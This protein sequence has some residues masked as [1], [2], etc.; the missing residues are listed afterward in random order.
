V[1]DPQGTALI[2]QWIS[3]MPADACPP[4]P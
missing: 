2:D 3:D 1:V 4:Q